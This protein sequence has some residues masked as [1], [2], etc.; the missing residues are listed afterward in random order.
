[1]SIL[2]FRRNPNFTTKL[3]K[4][5]RTSENSLLN[6]TS[7]Q[8]NLSYLYAVD[9]ENQTNEITTPVK[10]NQPEAYVFKRNSNTYSLEK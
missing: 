4:Q 2:D 5:G 10:K 8:R 9:K 3:R 1:M 7:N 6:L